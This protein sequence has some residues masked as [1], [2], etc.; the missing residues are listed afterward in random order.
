[1]CLALY[2][3]SSRP[4]PLIAWDPVNPAFHVVKAL[5]IAVVLQAFSLRMC[6]MPAH[7]RDAR[8]AFNYEHEYESIL[9]LR[10]YLRGALASGAEIE[11]FAVR[12]V[13]KER[14]CNT[15]VTTPDGIAA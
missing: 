13:M 11:A 2:L 12:W 3:A 14:P 8:Y 7:T 15:L 5:E 1:M 9:Q 10:D 4:L 6:T